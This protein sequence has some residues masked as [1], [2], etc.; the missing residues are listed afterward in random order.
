[1][2]SALARQPN[3][4]TGIEPANLYRLLDLIAVQICREAV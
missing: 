4:E 1:M 2:A 3:Y